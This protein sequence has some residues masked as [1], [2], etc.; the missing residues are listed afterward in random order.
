MIITEKKQLL[1]GTITQI[2][3]L[4][5]NHRVATMKKK[6][7]NPKTIMSLFIKVIISSVIIGIPPKCILPISS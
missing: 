3:F 6:T 4:K 1:M 5:T 2:T 7:P